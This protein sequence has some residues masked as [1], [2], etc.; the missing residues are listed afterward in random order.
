MSYSEV[1]SVPTIYNNNKDSNEIEVIRHSENP[2]DDINNIIPLALQSKWT[3]IFPL[4][5]IIIIIVIIIYIVSTFIYFVIYTKPLTEEEIRI[6][7]EKINRIKPFLEQK[8]MDVYKTFE[9]ENRGRLLVDYI[10]T[11]LTCSSFEDISSF[12]FVYYYILSLLFIL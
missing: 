6:K 8:I 1:P 10:H 4:I 11:M 7:L 3:V 2:Y 12:T 5:S 9:Y